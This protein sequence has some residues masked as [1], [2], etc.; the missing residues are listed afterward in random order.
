MNLDNHEL[1]M[2]VFEPLVG[3]ADDDETFLKF[4]RL[5]LNKEDDCEFIVSQFLLGFYFELDENGLRSL[6]I[7]AREL[8]LI[9][10][11]DFAIGWNSN[12]MPFNCP[13]STAYLMIASIRAIES[14]L[15]AQLR[16]GM[17]E[18]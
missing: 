7:V 18:R 11:T 9:D 5:D 10:T 12:L 15:G 16:L 2:S 13:T 17:K 3:G 8:Q 14:A 1:I 6:L 4:R